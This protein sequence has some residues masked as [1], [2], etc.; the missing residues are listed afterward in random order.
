MF[1]AEFKRSYEKELI[2]GNINN[3]INLGYTDPFQ[4]K[5]SYH[6]GKILSSVYTTKNGGQFEYKYN[7]DKVLKTKY[8]RELRTLLGGTQGDDSLVKI[9]KEI[10]SKRPI[11]LKKY[12]IKQNKV[13]SGFK[14]FSN[15]ADTI[16]ESFITKPQP[17]V[18]SKSNQT[19]TN[20]QTPR[21]NLDKITNAAQNMSSLSRTSPTKKT[22]PHMTIQAA[23]MNKYLK[24]GLL[25]GVGT[26]GV[27]GSY[28]LYR[29][30]R[31]KDKKKR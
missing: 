3:P 31:N 13:K 22:S 8:N 23:G 2:K 15:Y 27:V 19:I 12:F 29:Y 21:Q 1:L 18:L 26:L 11:G 6:R 28:G 7:P 14:S 25:A 4:N 24:G 5:V 17:T 16:K 9:S 20:T 10:K 30:N